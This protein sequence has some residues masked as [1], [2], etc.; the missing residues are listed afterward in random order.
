MNKKRLLGSILVLTIC[1]IAVITLLQIKV[2]YNKLIISEDKW[3]NIVNDRE[4]SSSIEIEDIEFNDYNLLVDNKNNVIYYSVVDTS[5]KYNPSIKIKT[6]KKVKVVINDK[7][8]DEVLENTDALKIMIYNNKEY[9][10]Y[11]LVPTL[12]PT[13]NIV[14]DKT[15]EN[16]SRISSFIEIFDNHVNIPQRVINSEG[17]FKVIEEDRVYSFSLTKTSLGNNRRENNISIFGMEKRDEYLIKIDEE[18]SRKNEK[19]VRLFINNEYKGIY[20]FGPKN[21]GKIDKYERNRENNK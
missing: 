19:Y 9:R 21:G 14:Y 11:S 12:Y 1:A 5:T 10:V 8:S 15:E 3:D 17:M 13:I 20:S 16:K 18:G 2:R 7:L 4:E 6:N